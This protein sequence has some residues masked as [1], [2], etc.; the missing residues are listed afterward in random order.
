MTGF[1]LGISYACGAHDYVAEEEKW[2]WPKAEHKYTLTRKDKLIRKVV[3]ENN[4]GK[5]YA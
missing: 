5:G 4:Y 3:L 2:V 1:T